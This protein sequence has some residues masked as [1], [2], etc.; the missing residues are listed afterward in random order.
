MIQNHQNHHLVK[1]YKV[2]V[3]KASPGGD[4]YPHKVFSEP[5]ISEPNSICTETYLIVDVLENKEQCE[6]L[7]LYMKTK[8]FRFLVSMVKNTQNISQSSFSLVPVLD[9]K[10]KWN[11][12]ILFQKYNITKE[13]SEFI[14]TLIK[15]M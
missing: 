5:I 7:I 3:S 2:L 1:K 8:F 11:D 4:E 14:D 9:M 13:E 6:N 10:Q 12:D 15:P